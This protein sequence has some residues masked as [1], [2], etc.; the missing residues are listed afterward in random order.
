MLSFTQNGINLLFDIT[1]NGYVI[2]K[3]F[4]KNYVPDKRKN[5]HRW[6]NIAEVQICGKNPDD[7]HF[8]K[9]TGGYGTYTLKYSNHNHY[10]NE[11][12]DKLTEDG[13]CALDRL[14]EFIEAERVKFV[15]NK[16]KAHWHNM[17]Q[18]LPSSYNQLRTVTMNY[19]VLI[20]IY[21][22][23]KSHKLDEWKTL[24]EVIKGLP[25]AEEL[26]LVKGE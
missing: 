14:I 5:D 8:G 24:A 3:D 11:L 9:H 26:I 7:H 4:S 18:L 21:Y 6:C 19:E 15:E 1:E 20:N 10:K 23:R 13:L 16:D 25:Y 22:A 2:L 12:G 17:I